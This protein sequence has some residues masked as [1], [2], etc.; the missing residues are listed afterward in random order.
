MSHG[1]AR[2]RVGMCRAVGFAEHEGVSAGPKRKNF[3]G[4]TSAARAPAVPPAACLLP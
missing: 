4:I 3:L 1:G 2:L